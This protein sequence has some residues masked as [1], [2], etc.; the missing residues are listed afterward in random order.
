MTL[1]EDFDFANA[2]PHVKDEFLRS[3]EKTRLAAGTQLYKW[4]DLHLGPVSRCLR[5]GTSL[6]TSTRERPDRG[7]IQGC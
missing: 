5:G 7:G 3:P 2:A 4:T 1:N 6:Q